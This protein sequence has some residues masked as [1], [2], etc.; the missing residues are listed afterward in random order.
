MGSAVYDVNY[1]VT[2]NPI[3]QSLTVM[4]PEGHT[5]TEKEIENEVVYYLL[6][7]KLR[8]EGTETYIDDDGNEGERNAS[9]Y[10]AGTN[11]LECVTSFRYRRTVQ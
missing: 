6:L 8:F 10:E 9:H 7:P 1:K 11:R 2:D 4:F 3:E 5:P